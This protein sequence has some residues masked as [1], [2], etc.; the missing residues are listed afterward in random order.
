MNVN[1]PE[2]PTDMRWTR[3][4]VRLYDGKVIP[5][6]RPQRQAAFLVYCYAYQGDGERYRSMGIRKWMGIDNPRYGWILPTKKHSR[7]R[8]QN[9]Q[10]RI[11]VKN[12]GTDFSRLNG[13]RC[14]D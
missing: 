12:A 5:G 3:Q 14:W 6:R 10:A 8:E 11:A 4:S 13:G 9:N 1:L 2:A 7:T